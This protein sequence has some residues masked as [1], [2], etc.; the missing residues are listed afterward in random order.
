MRL[1]QVAAV[2]EIPASHNQR[3]TLPLVTFTQGPAWAMASRDTGDCARGRRRARSPRVIANRCR[4]ARSWKGKPQTLRASRS[5]RLST[6]SSAVERRARAANRDGALAGCEA[7]ARYALAHRQLVGQIVPGQ[8][9]M[10]VT[11]RSLSIARPRAP[12][13]PW[14]SSR[15]WSRAAS[16]S[17]LRRP[18]SERVARPAECAVTSR[19]T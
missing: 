10:P 4:R 9:S 15:A 11:L 1:L 16:R 17:R 12:W 2:G 5:A 19:R 18:C 8:R 7:R 14:V 13:G 6:L 3:G